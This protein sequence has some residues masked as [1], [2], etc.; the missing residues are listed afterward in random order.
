MIPALIGGAVSLAPKL[1]GLVD[2][3]FTSDEEREAAKL[4]LLEMEQ[5]G[6]LA[7]IQVNMQEAKHESVFVAG[8]RPFI[9]WVCGSGLAYHFIAQ[10]FLVFALNAA[11]LYLGGPIMDPAMLPDLDVGTLYALVTGMLGLGIARTYEKY[12]GVNKNR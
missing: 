1:F 9:G 12:T 8:W 5:N 10:P 11:A 3:L 2:K 7:Q 6:E 4:K